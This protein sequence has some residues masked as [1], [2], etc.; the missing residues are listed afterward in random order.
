I[1]DSGTISD[2]G[3]RGAAQVVEGFVFTPEHGQTPTVYQRIGDIP[4]GLCAV[5]V[6]LLTGAS[7][8]PLKR[9]YWGPSTPTIHYPLT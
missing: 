6:L 2:I 3:K 7:I 9:V 8:L 1:Q 4:A 5:F